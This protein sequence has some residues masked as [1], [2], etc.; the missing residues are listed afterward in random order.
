MSLIVK[1]PGA[2]IDLS[3]D[4]AAAYPEGQHLMASS[5]SVLPSEAGG[6]AVLAHAF[7]LTSASASVGGGIVGGSY[8]LTNR[9]TLS[10]GQIDERSFDIRVEER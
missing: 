2:R 1:D 4:W 9:A 3:V 5:W 8:R 7:G 6:V 10:D